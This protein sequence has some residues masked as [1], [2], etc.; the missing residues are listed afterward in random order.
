M[1]EFIQT[2][3]YFCLNLIITLPSLL[4]HGSRNIYFKWTTKETKYWGPQ[5]ELSA[6]YGTRTNLTLLVLIHGRNGHYTN[7]DPLID[8]LTLPNRQ[9]HLI[10]PI[11]LGS[12]SRLSI[13]DEV[14]IVRRQLLPYMTTLSNIVLIG[15]SKGGLTAVQY[16][17]TYPSKIQKVITISSPLQGTK[18]AKYH[19]TCQLS[20][21]ELGYQ[22]PFIVNLNSQVNRSILYSIV[23]TCDHIIIPT[24]SAYLK[25]STFYVYRGLYSH[26]GILYSP[27]VISKVLSWIGQK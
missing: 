1:E 7:F 20:R 27:D 16:Q 14:Q 22:S 5:V 19:P 4:Y 17:F 6:L 24:S 8:A 25:G 10:L 9:R 15:L 12:N 3:I 2:V 11:D 13:F 26:S 18:V 21:N 23:P